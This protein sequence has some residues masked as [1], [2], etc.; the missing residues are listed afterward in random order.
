MMLPVP[1]SMGFPRMAETDESWSVFPSLRIY[2][3]IW[4]DYTQEQ[5]ATGQT[6]PVHDEEPCSGACSTPMSDS[7]R[8]LLQKRTSGHLYLE[9]WRGCGVQGLE[10]RCRSAG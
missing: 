9:L 4:S 7:L 6:Y 1:V 10:K 3:C 8:I 5:V 2:R